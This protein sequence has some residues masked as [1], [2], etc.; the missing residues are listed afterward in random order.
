MYNL[1][2]ITTAL[3]LILSPWTAEAKKIKRSCDGGYLIVETLADGVPP[4]TPAQWRVGDFVGRGSCGGAVPNRCR[5]RARD[6]LRRCYSDHWKTRWDRRKPK[7]CSSGVERYAVQDLKLM[8]EKTVCCSSFGKKHKKAS[9]AVYGQTAGGS[10]C[11]DKP[12]KL[13]PFD[14]QSLRKM[15]LLTSDYKVDCK[16]LRRKI[17]R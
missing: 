13:K 11:G 7:S 10:G 8:I 4:K 14:P 6:S 1:L 16:K 17:C 5:E 3:L 15:L 2:G 12:K 9:V